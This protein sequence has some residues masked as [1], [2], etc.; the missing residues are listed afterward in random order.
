MRVISSLYMG[1]SI[2]LPPKTSK[3]ECFTTIVNSP[4]PLNVV[5]K[6][7]ILDLCRGFCYASDRNILTRKKYFLTQFKECWELINSLSAKPQ[8]MIKH[9]QTIPWQQPSNCLSVFEHFVGLVLK[10]LT[11]FMPMFYFYTPL[12]RQK[13][14]SY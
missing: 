1:K 14:R 10:G 2:I 13:T 3:M 6:I 4:I 8:K 5:E 7:S 11:H 12:K 9:A